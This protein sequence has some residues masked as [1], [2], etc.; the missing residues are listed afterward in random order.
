MDPSILL[1]TTTPFDSNKLAILDS[2]CD[3]FFNSKTN[4]NQVYQ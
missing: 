2:L 3:T 4:S 1:D